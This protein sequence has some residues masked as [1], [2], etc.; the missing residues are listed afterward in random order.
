MNKRTKQEFTPD[1]SATEENPAQ[2]LLLN[3]GSGGSVVRNSSDSCLS[4]RQDLKMTGKGERSRTLGQLRSQLESI[5]GLITEI[6]EILNKQEENP[7]V[8]L[9]KTE[10]RKADLPNEEKTEAQKAQ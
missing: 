3:D 7:P 2:I 8:R 10:R 4:G 9:P 5:T 1:S 6:K